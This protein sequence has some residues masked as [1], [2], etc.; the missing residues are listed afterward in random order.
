MRRRTVLLKHKMIARLLRSSWRR[1]CC[2]QEVL[3]HQSM[4]FFEGMEHVEAVKIN[5][6]RGTCVKAS[7]V[8][9]L[10]K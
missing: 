6:P 1:H 9:N 4:K 2:I 7:K 8:H 10:V 5:D 3:A